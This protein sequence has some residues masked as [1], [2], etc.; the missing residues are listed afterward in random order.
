MID[1]ARTDEQAHRMCLLICSMEPANRAFSPTACRH[2]TL[3]DLAK[4]D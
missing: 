4:Q 1:A 3:V 2:P